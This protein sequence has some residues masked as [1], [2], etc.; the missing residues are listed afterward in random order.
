MP[1]SENRPIE[2]FLA[3]DLGWRP[4]VGGILA[5]ACLPRFTQV[6]AGKQ[7]IKIYVIWYKQSKKHEKVAFVGCDE[8][9]PA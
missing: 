4:N 6:A 8:P 5:K 7:S 1:L 3:V 9:T 2:A